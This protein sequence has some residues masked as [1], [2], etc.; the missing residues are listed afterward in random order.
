VAC[1]GRLIPVRPDLQRGALDQSGSEWPR[2]TNT[3]SLSVLIQT[4]GSG[5]NGQR[6]DRDGSSPARVPAVDLRRGRGSRTD[7]GDVSDVPGGDGDADEVQRGSVRL[8][9]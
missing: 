7:E 6:R 3:D 9:A 1:S 8:L 2:S 4:L 5:S